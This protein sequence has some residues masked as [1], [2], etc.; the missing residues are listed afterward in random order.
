MV[1]EH[2]ALYTCENSTETF[3]HGCALGLAFDRT[4]LLVVAVVGILVLGVA[5]FG[6]RF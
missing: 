3:I 1:G 5:W 4:T 6:L 2:G